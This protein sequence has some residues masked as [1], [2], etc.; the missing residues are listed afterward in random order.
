MAKV[1]AWRLKRVGRSD[2]VPI[3]TPGNIKYISFI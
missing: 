2:L 3:L 1:L